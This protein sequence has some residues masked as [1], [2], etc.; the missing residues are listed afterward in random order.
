MIWT[1]AKEELI[2]FLE[3]LNS[4]QKTIKFEHII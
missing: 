2:V 3:N 4:K 1:G